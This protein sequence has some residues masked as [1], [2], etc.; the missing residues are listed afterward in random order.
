MNIV[1]LL[2]DCVWIIKRFLVS[3]C[4][5]GVIPTGSKCSRAV[6][7]IE[8]DVLP[9]TGGGYRGRSPATVGDDQGTIL[10]AKSC[11]NDKG[12]TKTIK[13][14]SQLPVT[15]EKKESED[16]STQFDLDSCG[17][18]LPSG[19]T[20]E[21]GV[22]DATIDLTTSSSLGPVGVKNLTDDT[23]NLELLTYSHPSASST[24]EATVVDQGGIGSIQSEDGHFIDG[25]IAGQNIDLFYELEYVDDFHNQPKNEADPSS[26]KQATIS[27]EGGDLDKQRLEIEECGAVANVAMDTL[28]SVTT[29][30]S[31]QS[32]SA[33]QRRYKRLSHCMF[34]SWQMHNEKPRILNSNS[35]IMLVQQVKKS[36]ESRWH[37]KSCVIW[38]MA[39]GTKKV[40]RICEEVAI[41][42]ASLGIS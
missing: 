37:G 33:R 29:T 21:D 25:K 10:D 5:I 14:S 27:N 9:V 18:L 12:N 38:K 20:I 42:L 30:P 24:H 1:Y 2:S 35:C 8:D 32:Q 40:C 26:L 39:R 31:D 11:P 6:H 22:T 34:K 4:N 13:S 23:K 41:Q 3:L 19:S 17:S 15:E 36:M 16:D 7:G 28:S